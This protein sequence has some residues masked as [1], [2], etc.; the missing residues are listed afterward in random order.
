MIPEEIKQILSDSAF[1]ASLEQDAELKALE[2]ARVN[3]T[4]ELA[5]LCQVLG[6]KYRIEPVGRKRFGKKHKPLFLLPITPAVWSMWWALG[7][8]FVHGKENITELD[9]D[10][11]IYTL[12]Q[13]IEQIGGSAYQISWAADGICRK[14]G[15]DWRDASEVIAMM[16]HD[17]LRPLE[18]LP[19]EGSNPNCEPEFGADWLTRICGTVAERMN[20]PAH[21]IA[22]ERPLAE[23]ALHYCWQAA[24][25]N[26]NL[27]VRRRTPEDICN[28]IWERTL[29]LAELWRMKNGSK[30]GN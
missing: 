17:A 16:S 9:C 28:L 14:Y 24:A 25:C 12:S 6:G 26:S 4:D 18:L 2:L 21:K 1:I 27:D 23:V 22:V 5:A 19:T 8:P 15:I 10:V 3:P 7:L 20:Y 11:A 13:P 30:C 29:A